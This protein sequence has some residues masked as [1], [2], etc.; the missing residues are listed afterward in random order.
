MHCRKGR[1]VV[2]D[3]GVCV[4]V[5]AKDAAATIGRAIRSALNEREVS[6]VIVV[7]DGSGDRTA[8]VA[9][10]VDDGSGRLLVERLPVNRGPSAARNHALSVARAPLVAV[11]DSDDVL[12]PGRFTRLLAIPNWDIVADN[13]VFVPEAGFTGPDS[14]AIPPVVERVSELDLC[15][16]I[17]SSTGRRPRGRTQLGFLKPV[18]R[19]AMLEAT[20]LRYDERLRLGEDSVLYMNLLA[21][22]ARFRLTTGVGYLAV[23]RG[24]SL[25][26]RH[27]RE[28]LRALLTA[29]QELLASLDQPEP[30]HRSLARRVADT[31]RKWLLREFLHAKRAH[32]FAGALANVGPHP[33]AL[34][35]IAESVVR[36]KIQAAW[37]RAR[38]PL[39][40]LPAPRLLLS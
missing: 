35:D 20:G 9:R 27:G 17:D 19:T 36:D 21:A 16:M 5:A 15:R 29:E 18:I 40:H 32:G 25:S 12:L 28:D 26:A 8:E 24:T 11:L 1:V 34:Y 3:D 6:Q 23:E 31:R 10:A 37:A 39:G 7:D 2:S 22:G 30:V 38:P 4:I 33:L 14:V 13:I